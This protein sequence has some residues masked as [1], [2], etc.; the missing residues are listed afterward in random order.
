MVKEKKVKVVKE[1]KVRVPK[2][3]KGSTP[4]ENIDA[5]NLAHQEWKTTPQ[6]K[7]DNAGMR[8]D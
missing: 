5:M 7:Y 4:Q 3:S 8:I 1:K 6:V 2:E